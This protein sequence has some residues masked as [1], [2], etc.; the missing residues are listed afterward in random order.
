MTA[1]VS[2]A[3]AISCEKP[4]ETDTKEQIIEKE[5]AAINKEVAKLNKTVTLSSKYSDLQ[6]KNIKGFMAV[7]NMFDTKNVDPEGN[8]GKIL[9]SKLSKGFKLI[10]NKFYASKSYGDSTFKVYY[11]LEYG[12]SSLPVTIE[13]KGLIKNIDERKNFSQELISSVNKTIEAPSGIYRPKDVITT[14]ILSSIVKTSLYAE[15]GKNG[16]LFSQKP[17]VKDIEVVFENIVAP[18]ENGITELTFDIVLNANNYKEKS[19]KGLKLINLQPNT[20]K[21]LE[22]AKELIVHYMPADGNIDGWGLHLWNASSDSA[23]EK[24]TEW[25][26][27]VYF[28]ST[29][30]ADGYYVAKVPIINIGNGLNFI[31]H[32]GDIKNSPDDLEFPRN[33]FQAEFWILAGKSTIYTE[34]PDQTFVPRSIERTSVEKIQIQFNKSEGYET[35]KISLINKVTGLSLP[36]DKFSEK[37]IN[38]QESLA[39][40]KGVMIEITL[41]SSIGLDQNFS[42]KYDDNLLGDVSNSSTMMNSTELAYNGELGATLNADGSVVARIWAPTVANASINIYN[43]DDQSKLLKTIEVP[44]MEGNK[45]V[46]EITLNKANTGIENLDGYFY[47]YVLDGRTVLDPYA[48]SMAAFDPG[49]DDTVGKG[50]FV[51]MSSNRAGELSAARGIDALDGQQNKMVAYEVHVRDFTINTDAEDKGTFKG[52]ANWKKGIDHLKD[53]GI[54]HVQ[55]MPIQNYFTVNENNRAF[56]A[57]KESS[58]LSKD[59]RPNYNWG[60]DPHSYF[61]IEGWLSSDAS[62]P[63]AR[64]SELR[65][66]IKT[67]HDANIGVIADVV[68]NHV[69]NNRILNDIVNNVYFRKPGGSQPVGAPAVASENPMT[70]KLILDSIKFMYNEF[71]ID[72]FRFDLLGFIDTETVKLIREALPK[73]I[74]YGEAWNFTDLPSGKS[75]VI[76]VTN[77]EDHKIADLGYFNDSIRR[78]I[79]GDTGDKQAMDLGYINGNTDIAWL[80]RTGI[81][82]GLQNF[83]QSKEGKGD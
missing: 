17:D 24:G 67:L 10:L 40:N 60:Y 41:D 56:V 47:Q 26:K 45:T 65:L 50:A 74:L 37:I 83:P 68:Y 44:R 77:V 32:K 34:A 46:F 73:A 75:P 76:R 22:A 42:V 27:P 59:Y 64:I 12:S 5:L 6:P 58:E 51:D 25:T 18:V 13:V 15:N 31:V 39:K 19:I 54:T 7:Y 79:K 70:R 63:Y 82:A 3:I 1:I 28:E 69:Y 38:D 53:L 36:A 20:D 49:G 57:S 11:Q 66:L 35:G 8:D 78:S 23:I 80:V 71:G 55:L 48:K 43:K 81:I 16:A 33:K 29:I 21:E 14:D 72:G 4:T 61:A 9:N 52:F 2:S 62:D 30:G